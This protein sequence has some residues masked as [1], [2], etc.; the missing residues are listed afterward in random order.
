MDER[1]D[2][3]PL[4]FSGSL[5][6]FGVPGAVLVG[7]VYFGVPWAVAA[8]VHPSAAFPVAMFGPLFFLLIA[9]L[10]AYRLEGR[11]FTWSDLRDR[12]RLRALPGK[13]WLW[14]VGGFVVVTVAE[15][16][17]EPIGA[18]LARFVPMPP[19]LPEVM[20]PRTPFGG[21]PT[22]FMGVPLAGNA[23]FPL[24][25]LLCLVANIAGE[26]LWWR[27]YILPRQEL[28]FGRWAW[29]VNGLLWAFVVHAFMPWMFAALLP[30]CLVGP[31]LAQ[32]FRST[33]PTV[34][35]HGLGNLMAWGL[36]LAGVLGFGA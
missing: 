10:V 22:Q 8:G 23:L 13:A 14:V 12:F 32:R 9:A 35:I 27:G 30:G 1:S 3:K 29:L 21:V 15:T 7:T 18:T 16:L 28:A 6:L 24:L 31:Y 2:L 33:W 34:F 26:E 11:A 36:F 25:H 5:L 20:D 17:L 19:V 4:G